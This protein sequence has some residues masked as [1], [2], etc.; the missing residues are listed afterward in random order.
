MLFGVSAMAFTPPVAEPG[1]FMYDVSGKLSESDRNQINQKL[2]NLNSSTKNEIAV[3]V[4]DSLGDDSIDDAA[5]A[6]FKKWGVGKKGLDNG[7]LIMLSLGD[8]KMRIETGKGVE[9]ELTD[10]QTQDIMNH[11]MRPLLKS[12]NVA[13]AINAGI[14]GVSGTLESR[15]DAGTSTPTSSPHA[16]QNACQMGAGASSNS[17]STVWI[18]GVGIGAVL[19]LLVGR[20][21]LR[22]RRQDA[23]WQNDFDEFDEVETD[24]DE[25]E[26]PTHPVVPA[27]GWVAEH[28]ELTETLNKKSNWSEE[29][30]NPP[31]EEE[32]KRA[33]AKNTKP[34]GVKRSKI[35]P[36]IVAGAAVTAATAELLAAQRAARQQADEEENRKAAARRQREQDER[37]ERK[38]RDEDDRRRDD[39]SSSSNS[40][41]SFDFGS[42]S[43]DSGFGGG[44]DS[45]GGGDSSGGGSD[46]S[47]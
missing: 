25:D 26:T 22:R 14:D 18:F 46:S 41:S 28:K 30:H 44:G 38:R 5:N 34:E 13:G 12:N 23:L 1:R 45:F 16:G 42:S 31:S 24:E 11:K 15:K 21:V 17:R 33:Q 35:L 20:A 6:T 40:S 27:K 2:L 7:V 47:W 10:L 4:V 8:R 3:L 32:L 39:S 9:G 43:S 19:L 36:S 37:D 29:V